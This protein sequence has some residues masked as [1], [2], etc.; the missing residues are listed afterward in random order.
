MVYISARKYPY[1]ITIGVVVVILLWFNFVGNGRKPTRKMDVIGNGEI[2]AK[3]YRH[4][5]KA[6]SALLS[7]LNVDDQ[8]SVDHVSRD[9]SKRNLQAGQN[10][11]HSD[12]GVFQEE[13]LPSSVGC[14]DG[15]VCG[16]D[17]S[18]PIS[19]DINFN[20]ERNFTFCANRGNCSSVKV[21]GIPRILHFIWSTEVVPNIFANNLKR[22]RSLHPHW[23]I[24]F[25][26][27]KSGR[28]L[29]AKLEPE[30]LLYYD[31]YKRD[32]DRADM[33]RYV[34]LFHF[35]GAYFD[36]DS[37][38]FRPLD[39]LAQRYDCLVSPEP[40]ENAVII[41]KMRSVLA[42]SGI[43]CVKNHAFIRFLVHALP[44]HGRRFAGPLFFSSCF[45]TYLR[46]RL[47]PPD[48]RKVRNKDKKL[49]ESIS[50]VYHEYFE[51][52]LNN[53]VNISA[54]LN[55][56]CPKYRSQAEKCIENSE[57]HGRGIPVIDCQIPLTSQ[58][59]STKLFQ[60]CI[61]WIKHGEYNR[62]IG[63][64][65]VY[66]LHQHYGTYMKAN[67]ALNHPGPNI[68][69]ILPRAILYSDK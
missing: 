48:K 49:V 50:V 44:T 43:M 12:P 22:F 51:F 8:E 64:S 7:D 66:L 37:E 46:D 62:T 42:N 20:I 15:Y 59:W 18:H 14:H 39:S 47:S 55:R 1:I 17:Y 2:Y 67:F 26:T 36:L 40:I 54:I 13:F 10:C 35:G 56:E 69:E 53:I 41:L 24:Y 27:M 30:L 45:N 58:G 60:A 16:G 5:F 63:R 34:I 31:N 23:T 61:E 29:I 25:W 28:Q 3:N 52:N 19:W 6:D 65:E 9:P 32:V 4:Q 33:L 11:L 21:T 68:S 57:T 38:P